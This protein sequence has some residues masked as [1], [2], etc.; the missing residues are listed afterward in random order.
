MYRI[1]YKNFLTVGYVTGFTLGKHV[2]SMFD[3][4]ED[5]RKKALKYKYRFVAN[6]VCFWCNLLF[7]GALFAEFEV[8]QIPETE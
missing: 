5:I 8:E 7:K 3:S 6:I 4:L 2:E 1:K